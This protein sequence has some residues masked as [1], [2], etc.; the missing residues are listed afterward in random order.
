MRLIG[1]KCGAVVH[2]QYKHI[3]PSLLAFNF[4]PFN[5]VLP[6]C[7]SVLC[8]VILKVQRKIKVWNGRNKGHT[9]E[10]EDRDEWVGRGKICS[11]K[12]LKG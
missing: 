6:L 3:F 9:R 7:L 5:L 1:R 4:L 12:S 8:V 11:S 10:G 2:A